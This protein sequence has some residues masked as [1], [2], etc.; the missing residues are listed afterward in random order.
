MGAG[1]GGNEFP[2]KPVKTSELI[3]VIERLIEDY[4]S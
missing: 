3:E 4:Q 1:I 2:A